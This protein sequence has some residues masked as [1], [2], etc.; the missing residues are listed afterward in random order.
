MVEVNTNKETNQLP[1]LHSIRLLDG[2]VYTGDQQNEVVATWLN[3]ESSFR[4]IPYFYVI[5]EFERQ[6]KVKIISEN[7][8]TEKLF[9][10]RFAH[11]N[12]ILALESIT[13]PQNIR[14]QI[15]EDR[16]VILSS[17]ID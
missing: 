7:V 2:M 14:Y 12:M 17:A 1:S 16:R 15:N 10:G 9:T 8:N 4:S 11:N 13:I 6:Y 5:K 3:N